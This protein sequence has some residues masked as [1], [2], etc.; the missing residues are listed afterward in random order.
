MSFFKVQGAQAELVSAHK[1]E[2]EV[3][4]SN[5]LYNFSIVGLGD[6]A[7][8]EARDRISSAIKYSG[9]KSPKQKNQKVVISLAPADK[10]KIGANFDLP[11]AVGYLGAAKEIHFDSS[12]KLFIG[13]L[14]LDGETRKTAGIMK[15]ANFAKQSLLSCSVIITGF[16]ILF[17]KLGNSSFT[18]KS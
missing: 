16:V 11:M 12:D 2:I 1:I 15:I 5:G 17:L 6:K 3:D 4:I 7:V 13:E 10:K 14:S 18:Q 9:F 8:G